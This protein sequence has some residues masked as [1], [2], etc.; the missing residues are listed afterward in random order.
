[1][2]KDAAAAAPEVIS[3][4]L[5]CSRFC[6]T[7]FHQKVL[8]LYEAPLVLCHYV[9]LCLLPYWWVVSGF[10]FFYLLTVYRCSMQILIVAPQSVNVIFQLTVQNQSCTVQYNNKIT[11]CVFVVCVESVSFVVLWEHPYKTN[12]FV[13]FYS[14]NSEHYSSFQQQGKLK[15]TTRANIKPSLN[16]L[17]FLE[18]TCRAVIITTVTCVTSSYCPKSCTYQRQPIETVLMLIK[19]K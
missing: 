14:R 13:H 15:C 12:A 9:L 18:I 1:M 17:S 8:K 5:Y 4:C 6:W 10:V 7:L 11:W 16:C 19:I 3:C 2:S